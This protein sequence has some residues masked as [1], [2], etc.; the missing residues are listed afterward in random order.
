MSAILRRA[1]TAGH[2]I[3]WF[4]VEYRWTLLGL[5]VVIVGILSMLMTI[6]FVVLLAEIGFSVLLIVLEIRKNVREAR[7][8]KFSSRIDSFDDV[9]D[10]LSGDPNFRVLPSRAGTFVHDRSVS[11]RMRSADTYV[12]LA[13]N[14]YVVPRQL[15]PHAGRFLKHVLAAQ[16]N[17]FNGPNLGWNTN[18]SSPGWWNHD[19]EVVE[20]DHFR[21]IQSDEFSMVDV[22]L[23][24]RL[25]LEFGRALFIRRDGRIRDFQDSWLFNLIGASTIAI[26]TDGRLVGTQQTQA[27]MASQDL[28]APSG[29]GSAEPKDFRGG[30]R[31]TISQLAIN[32]STRELTEETGI[33]PGEMEASYLLGYGRWLDKAARGELLCVTFLNIDSHE[34]ALKR[35][36]STERTYTMGT[37][38]MRFAQSVAR[39][40]PAK[41]ADMLPEPQRP[42]MSVPLG[43]ALSLLAEEAGRP[44]SPVAQRLARIPIGP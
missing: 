28:M 30:R 25:L 24:M 20:G 2:R 19:I 38:S 31:L 32:A 22:Q 23:D 41:P 10:R 37:T 29:S 6:P 35:I 1:R 43:A 9:V 18:F 40:N 26:T 15:R 4:T 5:A 13:S 14:S 3:A 39:W 21:F 27:N 8:T 36:R 42:R 34:V 33:S 17:R 16:P 12:Q 7:R 44:D 11:E